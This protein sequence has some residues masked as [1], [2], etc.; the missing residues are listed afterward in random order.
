MAEIVLDLETYDPHLKTKGTDAYT[1]RFGGHIF[2][3]GWQRLGTEFPVIEEWDDY[4]RTALTELFDAGHTWIGANLKY[5]LGWLLSEGVL[6]PRHTKNNRF[7]DI[8]IDAPLLDET[9]LP[10]F[11]SLDGQCKHYDLPIK[12]VEKL[13]ENAAK[14]GIKADAKSIRGQL[15]LLDREVVADYLVHDLCAT[16]E[17]FR[18]QR[19]LI[20]ENKLE[21]VSELESLLLPVL[22]MME[23]Q[24]VKVDVAA[25]EDLY[26]QASAFIEDI[27]DKLK[28]ENG[29]TFVPLT[30]SA[31]LMNFVL[32]RGHKLP[33]TKTSRQCRAHKEKDCAECTPLGKGGKPRYTLD[34]TNLQRCGEIDPL[35]K[36]LL[37]ARKA[38]KIAKDFV[39]GGILEYQ[40]NG[41]IHANINQVFNTA[42]GDKGGGVRVGRLSM[43]KPNLQQIPKRDKISLDGLGGL[44]SAMRRIFVAEEGFGLMSADFSSQEPRWIIH[45]C[46]TW[47]MPGADKIGD[48][49]RKDPTISSHDIVAGGIEGD[50]P[51][52]QKRNLAKVINLGKG[53]EMG[54]AKLVANL[55]K[56]GLDPAQADRILEDFENNFPHVGA[57]SRAAMQAA[58]RLGY[59]RTYYGRKLHFNDFEAVKFGSGPAMKEKAAYEH[60]VVKK[61]IPIR[62]AYCYRAFNRIVQGSSADQTK[63]AMVSLWYDHGI[64]PTLQVHDELL[65]ARSTPE[66]AAIFKQ[67]MENVVQLTIPSLTEVKVGPNWK[68]G[69]LADV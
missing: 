29:G 67:V 63:A 31:A 36:E 27:S 54:K 43:S 49:Y 55:A 15:Y 64:L 45:W 12:P 10:G 50:L 26:T 5:D 24:G 30:A 13:L 1:R 4:A 68:D 65:D 8:L 14:K 34:D 56:E 35:I 44:G 17:V 48:L 66:R 11:Y 42:S 62:R 60:Y 41:R 23:H 51:Y 22:A 47:K 18:R 59:V 61:R 3:A 6:L 58:E 37:D 39:K 57:G 53:Y 40:H 32:E 16:G 52:K 20:A 25:A 38:E 46:E 9:Q 7:H 33:E 19:P 69:V 21:K 2:M 28:R